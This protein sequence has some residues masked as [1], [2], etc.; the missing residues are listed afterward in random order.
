MK[1]KEENGNTMLQQELNS[2]KETLSEIKEHFDSKF[3]ILTQN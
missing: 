3:K 2:I 1:M